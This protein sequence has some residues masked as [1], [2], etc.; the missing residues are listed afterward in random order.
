MKSGEEKEKSSAMDRVIGDES[1][2]EERIDLS[3]C[4]MSILLP[5]DGHNG[6]QKVH[7]LSHM[8]ISVMIIFHWHL[9][10]TQTNTMDHERSHLLHSCTLLSFLL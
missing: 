9:P 3:L 6:W 4:Q 2:G 10:A 7:M 1:G 8:V 5:N